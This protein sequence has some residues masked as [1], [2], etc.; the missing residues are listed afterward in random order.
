MKIYYRLRNIFLWIMAAF[1]IFA[2]VL[3]IDSS[4]PFREWN[5]KH[6]TC[7]KVFKNSKKCF[8]F[9][10]LSD[11]G[12]RLCGVENTGAATHSR[13]DVEWLDDN[14]VR[15]YS[16]DIGDMAYAR[17]DNGKWFETNPSGIVSGDY[18]LRVFLDVN[19]KTDIAIDH[20]GRIVSCGYSLRV[21]SNVN[22]KTDIAI[23]KVY[24]KENGGDR[25]I[26]SRNVKVEDSFSF[27][28]IKWG[29]NNLIEIEERGMFIHKIDVFS[30]KEWEERT[31]KSE[32]DSI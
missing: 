15:L 11:K 23:L 18:S 19:R 1:A 12:E 5:P 24:K 7:I 13:F 9:E 22:R 2:A 30:G 25:L 26:V 27:Y 20:N 4:L 31:D 6:D 17:D 16:G 14:K 10:I 29:K 8:G 3:F 32:L 28:K 21:F